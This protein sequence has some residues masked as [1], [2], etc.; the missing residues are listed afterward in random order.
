MT[1]AKLPENFSEFSEARKNGFLKIKELKENGRRVAGIFCTFT[2]MEIL[3]AAGFTPVS[4]CG[5]SAETIP[6]AEVHLPKNLC[7]LI[8]SSYGFAV[9]DKCPY[10]YFADLIVGETTCDGKKKMYELLGKLKETYILHLPQGLEDGALDYWKGELHR[11]IA[12]LEKQFSVEITEE[13]L[14]AAARLRNEERQARCQL[15][16]LQK[17][18]PPPSYGKLFYTALDGSGFLFDQSDRLTR[19][20]GLRES[21]ESAYAAGERPVPVA[22]KRI[23]ITGCPIGGVLEKTVQVIEDN[24]GVVVCFENCSGIKAAFQMI[25]TEAEDIVEAIAARYLEIGCSVM[26]PNEKRRELLARLMGEFSVDGVV[27][28]NLQA[29]TPYTVE[30]QQVRQDVLQ[31]GIPYLALETD[32]SQSDCGQLSTRLE[33]FLERIEK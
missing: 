21:L 17:Q 22:A 12:Y 31:L 4:L 29:C 13:A 8:K 24:G 26:S 20:T 30:A 6:A 15:M 14:R 27:E 25:D 18:V 5:M 9:S 7:P 19:L 10:T 33:A 1:T 11:F 28:V 32:Y 2:P 3:D 16:E 23:L